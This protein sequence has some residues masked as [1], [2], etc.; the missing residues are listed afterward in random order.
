MDPAAG[1]EAAVNGL[2]EAAASVMPSPAGAPV[3][4]LGE[5]GPI[6]A[7]RRLGQAQTDAAAAKRGK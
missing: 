2:I 1:I 3:E 4:K 5:G 7:A 6:E